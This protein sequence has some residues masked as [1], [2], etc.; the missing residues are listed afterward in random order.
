M[1]GVEESFVVARVE[2]DGRLVQNIQH[3]TEVR[4][5]LG[6][7]ADALGFAAGEG[8]R[9]AVE[10]EVVEADLGE[11]AQA[12]A[13]FRND[14]AGNLGGGA[15][16]FQRVAEGEG[17]GGRRVGE[18]RD[19]GFLDADMGG[20]F[21][22]ARAFANRAGAGFLI[23]ES[24][25]AALLVEFGLDGGFEI[26]VGGAKA[27]PD[28][29]K[30]SAVLAPAVRRVE[31]KEA[32]VEGLEG[33]L[34]RGA[35]HLGAERGGFA[36]GID[37]AGGAF[38]KAEGLAHEV[39]GFFQIRRIEF[40]DDGVDRVFLEA[41]E[42]L[43]GVHGDAVAIDDKSFDALAGGGAGDLGVEAFAALHEVREDFDRA[44]G[45]A[46][47]DLLGDGGGGAARNGDIALGA[48]LGAEF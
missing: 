7:E 42:F 3:A 8:F 25:V 9:G 21:V 34:A 33:A 41:L 28:L 5:E 44:L 31:G 35:I 24:L 12:L 20:G 38:A 1:E 16:E 30:T 32:G 18:V 27:F 22:E 11:E 40:A 23:L 14:V 29:A 47:A 13:D 19:G 17:G 45:G 2:A 26:M 37:E 46:G 36:L 43:E 39:V 6:G 48:K 4:A 10:R 15:G